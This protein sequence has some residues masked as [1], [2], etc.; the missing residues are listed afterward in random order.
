M[1]ELKQPIVKITNLHKTFVLRGTFPWSP[2]TDIQA[3]RGVELSIY[4]GEIVA[5]VGQSGSGKTTVSRMVLGLEEPSK[6]EIYLEGELWSGLSEAQRRKKRIRYQY[7]PQDAMAALDQQQTALEHIIESYQVLGG[8]TKQEA[9][10]SATKILTDLGL[11][12]RLHALPREMSGGEQR[13]VT[14]ARVLALDPKL[15]VADEP[16]SG[17]DPER[18]DSV[19][20]ELIGNLPKDAACILVTHDMSEATQWCDRIYAMLAGRVI[21]EIDASPKTSEKSEN[22]H[23]KIINTPCHPYSRILFDP[24][25]GAFP[26]GELFYQ[27]CPFQGDCSILA[28]HKKSKNKKENQSTVTES[29]LES[30]DL[31]FSTLPLPHTPN[32]EDSNLCMNHIPE[33]RKLSVEQRIACHAYPQK[34]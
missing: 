16:T 6:G 3:V 23:I 33:L 5:L 28:T 11:G 29:S 2:T 24:W 26:K 22:N 9:L 32:L 8:K 34:T 31:V 25:S 20:E 21:E 14:L 17:L 18:R 10:D 19:L 27:G 4:P 13:R 15:V 30:T 7:I 1:S 12:Q